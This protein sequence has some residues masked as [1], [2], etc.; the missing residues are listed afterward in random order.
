MRRLILEIHPNIQDELLSEQIVAKAV[1]IIQDYKPM[2]V[3]FN[4]P[5]YIHDYTKE[6]NIDYMARLL[7]SG[8][9]QINIYLLSQLLNRQT[10]QID[11][12][13]LSRFLAT[14]DLEIDFENYSRFLDTNNLEKDFSSFIRGI[15]IENNQ[16]IDF[17]I[18]SRLLL[19][20]NKQV[21]FDNF[22]MGLVYD[23]N[24][25]QSFTTLVEGLIPKIPTYLQATAL[26]SSEIKLT[27]TDNSDN[28][29]GFK[30][31]RK[32]G[33]NGTWNQVATVGANVIQYTDTG[34]DRLT[35]YYYR[36]KAYN[37]IGDSNYSYEANAQTLDT[38]PNTPSS[39]T[40]QTISSSQI[41]LTWTDNSDNETGFKIERKTG[42]N[43]TWSQVATVG[44]NTTEFTNSGLSRTTTYYYRVRAYNS[45]GNSAYSNEA[46]ATTLD[47]IPNTP[48]S[49][50][51][52][53]LSSS[54]IK[55]TWSDN[56][57]NELGFKIERKL[58]TSGTWSQIATVGA[59]VEQYTDSGLNSATI[60]YYRVR[61]YN[62]IGNSGYSNE[63]NAKT[64]EVPPNAPS[65]LSAVPISYTEIRLNWSD[66]SNNET[67][68]KIERKTGVDG[69]W[70]Q[71]TTV[72]SNTTQYI[73][74]ELEIATTYIYRIRAY[75]SAGNSAYS[76][77]AS[78]T[79]HSI[80]PLK[81]I[82]AMGDY[83]TAAI[84]DSGD[85][86]M[87]GLNN[88]GQL[89]N[90]STTNSEYFVKVSNLSHN[91]A[92]VSLGAIHSGALTTSGQV[93]M[94]GGNGGGQLGDGTYSYRTTPY[95]I[96][97][98]GQSVISLSL[99]K[100]WTAAVT[101][102]GD[103]YVWG[104]NWAGNLGDGGSANRNTP[105]KLLSGKG[106]VEVSIGAYFGMALTSGGEIW[107]WR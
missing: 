6:I 11:F 78:A 92:A 52:S 107:I 96:S 56:S 31:E 25:Q 47:T 61:A 24:I 22:I 90:N 26:S 91:V 70:S 84:N 94:W 18:I 55:L 3:G 100:E 30:I 68:F 27:W 89:G 45:I 101:S 93:Y 4:T 49:L 81:H 23:Y 72:G 36:V 40:A 48:S 10:E 95:Q 74:N 80:T 17:D 59:N 102:S 65:N 53:V 8:D 14:N 76:N 39:L 9:K 29:T 50:S 71:I 41:K 21:V 83:H 60:Y 58:G 104:E 106:F 75:N 54:Q 64:L 28:E 19:R 42:V 51:A 105:Y 1:K 12:I 85:L 62:N 38:I 37:N 86:Y 2:Y 46:N 99:G 69:T 7:L 103:L 79:T 34:L 32:T 35:N 82:I 15:L 77:E 98:G 5:K 44:A 66:N 13:T 43:G 73:D 33:V 87:V 67:G 20:N 16:Q 63:T 88:A 57:D 97:V